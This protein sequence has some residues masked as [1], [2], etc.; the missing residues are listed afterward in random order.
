MGVLVST[1]EDIGVLEQLHPDHVADRV[2]LLVDREDGGV[3]HLMDSYWSTLFR[4]ATN[5]Y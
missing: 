2:I 4:R 3:R 5:G 1:E